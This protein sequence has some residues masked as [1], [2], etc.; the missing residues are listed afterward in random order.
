MTVSANHATTSGTHVTDAT[1]S[2]TTPPVPPL[3]Y[4]VV[5]I[6]THLLAHMLMT[7]YEARWRVTQGL[8][9]DARIVAVVDNREFGAVELIVSSR[10]LVPGM[11][12]ETFT[13]YGLPE[14]V[15]VMER[16]AEGQP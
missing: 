11:C 8:P 2:V 12:D 7:G 9:D 3:Q 1:A 10:K 4:A 6:S 14:M 5:R 16:I 15:P 13:T